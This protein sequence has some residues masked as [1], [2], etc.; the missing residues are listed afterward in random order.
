MAGPSPQPPRRAF[1]SS[2][3]SGSNALWGLRA[4]TLPEVPGGRALAGTAVVGIALMFVSCAG[5]HPKN[6][7]VGTTT[8]SRTT[9]S[10]RQFPAARYCRSD[11]HLGVHDASR[12]KVI[13]PCAKFVGTVVEGAERD[14]RDGDVTFFVAPDHGYESMLNGKNRAKGGLHIEIVPMDQPDCQ[15]G[16]PIKGYPVTNLGVCSGAKVRSPPLGAHVRVIGPHV[17]D[18]WVGW[19]EIHPAWEVEILG[20]KG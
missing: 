15:P 17:Y 5:S 2:W 20:A 10:S 3:C 4:A 11:P 16:Q 13:D 9:T 8:T 19:N 12:L 18:S 7:A 6:S 1:V 14:R